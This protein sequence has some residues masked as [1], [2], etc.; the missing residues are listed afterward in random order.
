MDLITTVRQAY[1]QHISGVPAPSQPAP[2]QVSPPTVPGFNSAPG[3]TA[4]GSD[5]YA[6][7]GGYQAYQQYCKSPTLYFCVSVNS[8]QMRPIMHNRRLRHHLEGL[9]HLRLVLP[10][11]DTVSRRMWFRHP[12]RLVLRLMVGSTLPCHLP[13]DNRDPSFGGVTE[14]TL[15]RAGVRKLDVRI[16]RK[17]CSVF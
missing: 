11:T 9:G 10:E 8:L 5:P 15:A 12:R 4:P 3:A 7:Y 6:A 17:F 1:E 14:V 13:L 2:Q 16:L